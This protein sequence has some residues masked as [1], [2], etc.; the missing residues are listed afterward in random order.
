M[1][2]AVLLHGSGVYDGTEIHEAVL[3]LLAIEEAGHTYACI[4]PNINQHHVVNHLNGEEMQETRNVLVESARI[5]RGEVKDVSDIHIE[6]Y[7]ALLMPGGFGTAKNFTKWA[8]EGPDG[9]I[10]ES[11]KNLVLGFVSA[12]KPIGALCMSPTTVAKALQ[13]SEF[14]ATL[15]VG[16]TEAAS[17]YDIGAISQGVN[18]TGAH[19][20]MRTVNEIA[21]DEKLKIVTAPCYMMEASITEVRNNI[22]EAVNTVIDLASA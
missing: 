15:T 20:E 2:I 19:A 11:I 6:D 12:S 18:S 16:S 10:V 9:E 7:D 4:A 5:A 21:V 1:N 17:P 14:S 3:T 8:F 13:G 22:K